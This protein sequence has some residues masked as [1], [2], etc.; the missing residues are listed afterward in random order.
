MKWKY[1]L[2]FEN[3]ELYEKRNLCGRHVLRS[4]FMV[5]DIAYEAI[6]DGYLFAPTSFGVFTDT[7]SRFRLVYFEPYVSSVNRK[8]MIGG[9][10]D[11]LYSG[12]R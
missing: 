8:N 7:I 10:L 2:F 9:I 6:L 4:K 3:I 1:K 11:F 5:N 12:E